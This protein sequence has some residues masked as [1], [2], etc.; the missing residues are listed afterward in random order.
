HGNGRFGARFGIADQAW[1]IARF[2]DLRG[3]EFEDDI[4]R[5][6][7]TFF[8]RA[9]S[10]HSLDKRT[11][12]LGQAKRFRYFARYLADLHAYT[13]ARHFPG[14]LELFAHTDC[15][16]DRHGKR[17]AHVAA[18]ATIDLRVNANHLATHV[19]QRA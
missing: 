3:V 16:V 1:Q 4:A 5:L 11:L 17:N 12:R 18:G 15:F 14:A 10:F 19:D 13:P 9:A 7:T 6:D 8:C 2:F